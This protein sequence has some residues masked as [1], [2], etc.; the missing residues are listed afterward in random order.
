MS[1]FAYIL[2]NSQRILKIPIKVVGKEKLKKRL[3]DF[4][5]SFFVVLDLTI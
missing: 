1:I 4:L 2:T 5:L 3:E